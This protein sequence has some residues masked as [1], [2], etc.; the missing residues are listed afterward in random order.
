MIY[1][2]DKIFLD[3]NILVYAHDDTAGS[4]HER[5]R[6]IFID[7]WESRHGCLSIQVSQEFFVT[8]TQKVAKPIDHTIAIGIIRDLS[9]WHVHQPK[10]EDVIEAIDLYQ[11][12]QILFRDAMILQSAIKLECDLIWSEDLNPGQVYEGVKLQNPFL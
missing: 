7:L 2:P 10:P 11:R 6:D 3:T 9:Y 12:N 5:A 1:M 4:K 8:V